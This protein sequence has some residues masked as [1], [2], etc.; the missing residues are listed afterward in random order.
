[1]QQIYCHCVGETTFALFGAEDPCH[2]LGIHP[3]DEN[4]G[5]CCARPQPEKKERACCASEKAA[6]PVACSKGHDESGLNSD[7]C[8]EK[9]V[10]VYQLHTE[11]LEVQK[12]EF[13]PFAHDFLTPALICWSDFASK[14]FDGRYAVSNKAPPPSELI[15]RPDGR[16]RCILQC[17]FLC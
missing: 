9:T 16:R 7:N 10:K 12:G 3:K 6:E 1:M 4:S 11:G 5:T 2:A 13:K 17:S 15:P 8:M 14:I